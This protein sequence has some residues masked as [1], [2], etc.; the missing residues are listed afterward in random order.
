MSDNDSNDDT[1]DHSS[2]TCVH[3]KLVHELL[4]PSVLAQDLY[5]FEDLNDFEEPNESWKSHESK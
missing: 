5:L 3:L 2:N 1:C 4:V